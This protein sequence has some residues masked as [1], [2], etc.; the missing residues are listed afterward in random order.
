[1]QVKRAI[2]GPIPNVIFGKIFYNLI[3][4]IHYFKMPDTVSII[5]AH[6]FEKKKK[7]EMQFKHFSYVVGSVEYAYY[8][9]HQI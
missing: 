5:H 9:S 4:L 8:F 7:K 3:S 1:M 2:I 6:G